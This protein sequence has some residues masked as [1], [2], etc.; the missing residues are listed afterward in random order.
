MNF[1]SIDF[2]TDVGSF[3]FKIKNKSFSKILQS[4]K[5]SSDL[6][7][8][9]IIDFLKEN[10]LD[11]EDI[12]TIFVNMGPGSYSGLRGAISTAKGMSISKNIKLLG[13]DNFIWSSARFL[14]KKESIYGLTKV[15]EK[16]FI[17]KINKISPSFSNIREIT[18]NEIVKN[19]S[20]ELKVI[21][22]N[23]IKKFDK[24]ILDLN[25]INIVNLDPHDLEFLHL[26]GLLSKDFIKPLYL[27]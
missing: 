26:K 24:K 12:E 22:K 27:S 15:R 20:S 19:Y 9:G 10:N 6:I 23:V 17:K 5:S 13:Y 18:K 3:F 4:D 25:N 7:M 8:Q 1:L 14:N 16:Y 2:S 11:F 21:P